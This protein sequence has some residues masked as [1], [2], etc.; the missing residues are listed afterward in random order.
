MIGQPEVNYFELEGLLGIHE[1]VLRLEIAM[2]YLFG[3][4]ILDALD[5]LGEYLSGVV[6]AE[7]TV[8]LQS[9]EQLTSL[10]ETNSPLTY[11]CTR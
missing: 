3:V 7:V 8:L 5:D 6:L 11:S 1:E 4:H 9:A 10:A 2:A